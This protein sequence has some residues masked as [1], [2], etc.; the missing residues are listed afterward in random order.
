M[1]KLVL[2]VFLVLGCSKTPISIPKVGEC[3][4]RYH[5]RFKSVTYEYRKVT[6]VV[7]NGE[8]ITI[9]YVYNFPN[10]KN[11][12]KGSWYQLS[13]FIETAESKYW[14][15]GEFSDL[16]IARKIECPW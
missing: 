8:D 14:F 7:S 15:L 6:K 1:I 4:E 9:H 10:S 3:Y 5:K 16:V 12:E 2:L 11:F 13:S